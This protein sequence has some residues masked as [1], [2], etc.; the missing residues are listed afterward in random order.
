METKRVLWADAIGGINN[1]AV[2]IIVRITF[3]I[4]ISV[5]IARIKDRVFAL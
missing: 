1:P 4:E 3:F 5:C 2:E